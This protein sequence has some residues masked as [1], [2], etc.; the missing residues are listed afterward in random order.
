MFIPKQYLQLTGDEK[1]KVLESHMFV[2]KKR[3]GETKARGKVHKYLGMTLDF[4]T[5]KVLKVTMI[6]YIDEIIKV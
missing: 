4:A 3:T 1:N 5:A 6:D 2:I